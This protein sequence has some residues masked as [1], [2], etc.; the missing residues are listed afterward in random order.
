V[1][2]IPTVAELNKVARASSSC[3]KGMD[4]FCVLLQLKIPHRAASYF[5]VLSLPPGLP[6]PFPNALPSKPGRAFPFPPL[7]LSFLRSFRIAM[8]S[9]RFFCL[10]AADAS[11]CCFRSSLYR[12]HGQ[13]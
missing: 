8:L 6:F 5:L 1:T 3:P 10:A 7:S 9:V 11:S 4:S 2:V 12:D 13:A